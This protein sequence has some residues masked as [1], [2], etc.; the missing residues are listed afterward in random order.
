MNKKKK[1]HMEVAEGTET[2][3]HEHNGLAISV[4]AGV[5][6]MFVAV[7]SWT[8]KECAAC[9]LVSVRKK[10][11]KMENNSPYSH[12]KFG[13]RWFCQEHKPS[14]DF[15]F[16]LSDGRVTYWNYNPTQVNPNGSE[17]EEPSVAVRRIDWTGKRAETIEAQETPVIT[18]YG[19]DF[20]SN[21]VVYV[22]DTNIWGTVEDMYTPRQFRK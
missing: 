14:C 4:A 16:V 10:A 2:H 17:V 20:Y 18:G 13:S 8:H 1:A 12:H 3:H 7:F 15:V 9:G 5:V 22:E 6:F 11:T 19:V 21:V